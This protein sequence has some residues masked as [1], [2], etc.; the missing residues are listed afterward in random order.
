M[1]T[2]IETITATLLAKTAAT[3]TYSH[4][5]K[6]RATQ[7]QNTKKI[8]IINTPASTQQ[9]QQQLLPASQPN[10]TRRA[11]RMR[12]TPTT[13]RR[14]SLAIFK[15]L[16]LACA[17]APTPLQILL[18]TILPLQRSLAVEALPITSKPIESTA[19]NLAWQAWLMLPPEQKQLEK[20]R[21]VTPKS[22]F[23]LPFRECPPGHQ[24]FQSRC[25]PTVNI[26][27][28]ELLKQQVLGLFLGSSHDGGAGGTGT[29]AD[30]A[31]EFDYGDEEYGLGAG[32]SAVMYDAPQQFSADSGGDGGVATAVGT[33]KT[34]QQPTHMSDE[35]LKFNLFEQKYPTSD[36]ETD[37]SSGS[38]GVEGSG[39]SAARPLTDF[40]PGSGM[41]GEGGA[42]IQ[43]AVT[44]SAHNGAQF[45]FNSTQF[46]DAVQ[47]FMQT[48]VTLNKTSSITNVNNTTALEQHNN[49]R[50]SYESQTSNQQPQ[51][52][53]GLTDLHAASSNISAFA[54]DEI[55]AI[56]L[57]AV[58]T[59]DTS[60]TQVASSR[61]QDATSA[62]STVGG[63][64]LELQHISL[65]KDAG[66][67]QLHVT[68]VTAQ[69]V[70]NNRTAVEEDAIR[71]VDDDAED[72]V[73]AAA[74]QLPAQQ[75]SSVAQF[76][77]ADALLP[78]STSVTAYISA[79]T[80]LAMLA[81]TTSVD[82]NIPVTTP[83]TK[84]ERPRSVLPQQN[85][86]KTDTDAQETRF[87]TSTEAESTTNFQI[88]E[89][90]VF[91]A[92]EEE[93]EYVKIAG[94]QTSLLEAIKQQQKLESEKMKVEQ[95]DDGRVETKTTKI[96]YEETTI[97]TNG[98][99]FNDTKITTDETM[100]DSTTTVPP[101]SFVA[102]DAE[103]V[104]EMKQ[105]QTTTT[106]LPLYS[107][108]VIT[109]PTTTAKVSLTATTGAD[110]FHSAPTAVSTAV[111]PSHLEANKQ[112]AAAVSPAAISSIHT[113]EAADIT[114]SGKAAALTIGEFSEAAV[115]DM[116]GSGSKD[117]VNVATS[118]SFNDNNNKNKNNK[119]KKTP[120]RIVVKKSAVGPSAASTTSEINIQQELRMINE[121]VKGHRQLAALKIAAINTATKI[122]ATTTPSKLPTAVDTKL[123][124]KKFADPTEYE[125][126]VNDGDIEAVEVWRDI[127][128]PKTTTQLAITTMKTEETTTTKQTTQ[129]D[130]R[131]LNSS[132]SIFVGS[133]ATEAKESKQIITKPQASAKMESGSS[134]LAK[135]EATIV[136]K[137]KVTETA[138][139]IIE[140]AA[141][142]SVEPEFE[143]DSEATTTTNT[144]A[145]GATLWSRIMPIFGFGGGGEVTVE[146]EELAAEP[147]PTTTT[148]TTHELAGTNVSH[149]SSIS[150]NKN[151]TSSSINSN[152]SSGSSNS[153][154]SSI[155]DI[156]SISVNDINNKNIDSMLNSNNNNVDSHI[157]QNSKIIRIDH[158]SDNG[159]AAA[160]TTTNTLE[161]APA[162]GTTT[163]TAAKNIAAT[164]TANEEDEP[165]S[166]YWWLPTGWRLDRGISS[167]QP[168]LYRLWSAFPE[169]QL[170][171]KVST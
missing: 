33:L 41:S 63:D 119:N 49:N 108:A 111:A 138:R 94:E 126:N 29:A 36:Y 133:A 66:S 156:H 113:I 171:T 153:S 81:T 1:I 38:G 142:T 101:V 82:E 93:A 20:S 104:D 123:E 52:H 146:V 51:Q 56:I 128:E 77:R 144:E 43:A 62:N 121:L 4:K 115:N 3:P 32:E 25:I 73:A 145:N 91:E 67:V 165:S 160:V 169:S 5:S 136:N 95:A 80:P 84:D 163:I 40:T 11:I 147:V 105:K 83:L 48:H 158:L 87:V 61:A 97:K 164:E 54:V 116:P 168:L 139:K 53:Q 137:S 34:P 96:T 109:E 148:T 19:E 10:A 39:S 143:Y 154:K 65:F 24:L 106:L 79:T 76:L 28:S 103:T 92:N 2:R 155:S 12:T 30:N 162:T 166:T 85:S 114:G 131:A 127:V 88:D 23:S 13:M 107:S 50:T 86:A 151:S 31:Y 35:P 122:P 69:T 75:Q 8:T 159:L 47:G 125:E 98:N 18:P 26:N 129:V 22:I 74:Q 37:V 78:L 46:L 14:F 68:T 9:Q 124:M 141:K 57:P 152:I 117:L 17:L 100:E 110:R 44:N 161:E 59:S 16:L 112:A 6:S 89:T 150:S 149:V 120:I 21:K 72:L 132:T 167:E 135:A 102:K 71:K 118:I 70:K 99:I 130:T 15:F 55:D 60:T 170:K 64:D 140:L 134:E 157:R 7:Q 58:S 27:Q 45:N 90:T 42:R